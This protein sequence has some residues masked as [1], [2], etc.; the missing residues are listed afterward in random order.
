MN[1]V[2]LIV[3]QNN[4]PIKLCTYRFQPKV[5][6]ERPKAIIIQFHG[7]RQVQDTA[8]HIAEQFAE[9]GYC[10]VGYDYRGHGRSEGIKG[11]VEDL[12]THL[13]DAKQFIALI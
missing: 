2:E 11:Y 5:N 13:S 7:M 1:F 12:Q 4:K 6:P 8:A 10:V 3:K 9:N